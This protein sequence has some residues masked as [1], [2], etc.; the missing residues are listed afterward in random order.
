VILSDRSIRDQLA[1]RRI[2][3]DSLIRPSSI[4]VRISHFFRYFATTQRA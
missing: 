4:D 3:I 2:V 1:A